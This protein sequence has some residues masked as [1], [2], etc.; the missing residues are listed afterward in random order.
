MI[1]EKKYDGRLQAGIKTFDPKYPV[2]AA[3]RHLGVSVSSTWR[4][5]WSGKLKSYRV[6]GR[7]LVGLSHI[8]E[9]LA[10]PNQKGQV[11]EAGE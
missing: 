4:L 2:A 7:T 1:A 5:I 8:E 11:Q 6:G 10:G 9:Y 3:A